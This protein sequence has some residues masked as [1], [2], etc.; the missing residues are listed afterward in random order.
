MPVI[1]IN[2]VIGSGTLEVGHMVA[3]NMGIN[4][5]DRYIFSEAARLVGSPI[6]QMIEKEQRVIPFRE[7]VAR[8]MQTVLERSAVAGDRRRAILRPGHRNAA[9]GGLYRAGV[10][11]RL[12]PPQFTT[13]RSLM[14]LLP[15]SR[16][17]P[18]L[19]MW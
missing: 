15:S 5:V 8:F 4:Y 9:G 6:G 2:G 10:G 19:A 12:P 3:Q 14:P 18:P 16:T 13:G 11:M 17:S 7:K 1:T